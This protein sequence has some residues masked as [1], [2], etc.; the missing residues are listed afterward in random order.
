MILSSE[1]SF[2]TCHIF[3]KWKPRILFFSLFHF[4]FRKKLGFHDL[5]NMANLEVFAARSLDGGLDSFFKHNPL[6][7]EEWFIPI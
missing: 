2:K 1:T 5:K 3:G 7:S 4:E 6:I